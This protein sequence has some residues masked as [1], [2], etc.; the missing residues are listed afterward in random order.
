MSNFKAEPFTNEFGE[1]IN[2]GDVVLYAATSWKSTSICRG[3]YEGCTHGKDW[4][5]NPDITSVRVRKIGETRKKW[6]REHGWQD[7]GKPV[8]S[9]LTLK[10]VYKTADSLVGMTF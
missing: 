9:I 5:G 8:Y 3:V 2:P 1:V 10:R 7:T 6:T 4:R